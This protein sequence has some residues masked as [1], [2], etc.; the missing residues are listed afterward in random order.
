MQKKTFTVN[1]MAC[2][3]CQA[4]VQKHVSAVIGVSK[5]AVNLLTKEMIV[6]F[7]ETVTNI[8]AICEAV[9]KAG[10]SV[11]EESPKET[12]MPEP[13]PD[14]KKETGA[15]LCRI[16]F[17][18]IFLLP[19][20]Y[21]TMGSML[22]LPQI[23][24]VCDKA[25]TFAAVQFLL[26]L[27]I[28][29]F[30]RQFFISGFR[31]LFS[32][33][34]D[35]DSL[36]ALG[37][38]A[39]VLYSFGVWLKILFTTD[40]VRLMELR[41]NLYFE[42]AGM[43]LV[44]I[45]VGKYLE[46]RS[47]GR[48]G[49]AIAKLIALMP[50]TAHVE[51]N[52]KEIE[53]PVL[54]IRQGDIVLLRS[55]NSAPVDGTVTD[56]SATLNQSAVTGESVP[57]EK[58]AGQL[59]LSGSICTD[60]FLRFRAEK[61][62]RD[63]TL[64]R[65]IE[66]VR[67]AGTSKAPIARLADRV[68]AFFV[69]AVITIAL[70]TFIY[71]LIAGE[72]QSAVSCAISVLVISCPCALG[73]A[74]PVAIMVGTGRGAELGILFKNAE[75][76]ERLHKIQVAVFDKTGTLTTGEPQISD[77]APINGITEEELLSLAAGIER[78]SSHPYAKTICEL[79]ERRKI[80]PREAGE[81]IIIPGQGV[82][83]KVN[84]GTKLAGAG[85]LTFLEANKIDEPALVSTA[86]DLSDE[87]KTPL[88]FTCGGEAAGLIALADTIRPGAKEAVAELEK[89]G[90][91][92]L[93]LTGD[94]ERTARAVA[95]QLGIRETISGVLPEAKAETIRQLTGNGT[96][97]AMV[98]DGIN[99]APAL[100]CADVGIAV[101]TGTEIALDA[102]DVVLA[103][104]DPMETVRAVRL[105]KAVISNVKMNLFW[106]FFYN[107]L[108]IPLAAGVLGLKLSPM[109]GAFAMSLSSVCVVLNALRLRNF[110]K[111]PVVEKE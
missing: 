98:G 53:I 82:T 21:L 95:E 35:M 42:A 20:I 104:D 24:S 102:A 96:L 110:E 15:L 57:V 12:E 70:I 3:A 1:G 46:K 40:P 13:L 79:A 50:K 106:A 76:L 55:G 97:T 62:G 105:S 84:D 25:S 99:D 100:A 60:G 39:G 26:L 58:T 77:I 87:G 6:E 61:V 85:N 17:S 37:A 45:T 11:E 83:A 54:Q 34:P 108:G 23:R 29:F 80:K 8:A 111:K 92:T 31:R 56:G 101:G 109:I 90:I 32:L 86:Q 7:D 16:I 63:T 14:N 41:G 2:A 89:M 91:H 30:N 94:N 75:A 10:F 67:E 38:S 59:I 74:T 48:T 28:L 64:A 49:D 18:L 22:G 44:L 36:I 5:A 27:P 71:W 51:R 103:N 88:F 4:A 68:S 78:F 93:L 52:G 81:F 19:L 69:P 33:S 47:E 9:R 66:L 43:I 65:V 72:L 73:L 107:I